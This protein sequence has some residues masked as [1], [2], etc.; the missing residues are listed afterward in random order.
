MTIMH[1][2]WGSV[3]SFLSSMQPHK[4]RAT[5]QWIM[6]THNNV[7][8]W[9]A[10]ETIIQ[11]LKKPCSAFNRVTWNSDRQQAH[12]ARPPED[13]PTRC[14]SRSASDTSRLGLFTQPGRMAFTRASLSRDTA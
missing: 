1:K 12:Q 5:Q 10:L 3:S 2:D 8:T 13:L 14:Q 4:I 11:H 9:T 6:L 7:A